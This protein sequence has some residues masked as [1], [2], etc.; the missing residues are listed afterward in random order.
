MNHLEAKALVD[1]LGLT[2]AESLYTR[3]VAWHETNYGGGW[4]P[5]GDKSNNMGA[6]LTTHPDALSFSYQDSKFDDA[7]GKVTQYHAQF[8]GYPTPRDGF[9]ALIATLLKP[10]V[11]AALASGNLEGAVASQYTN[12]YFQGLHSHATAQ[13][14]AE[15]VADYLRAVSSALTNIYAATHEAQALLPKDRAPEARGGSSSSP[16]VAPLL[17]RGEVVKDGD[18]RLR[19]LR[20]GDRGPLIRVWQTLLRDE[21]PEEEA[22]GLTGVFDADTEIATRKWQAKM[23]LPPDGV[24]GV[25]SWSRMLS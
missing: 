19:T 14:N 10:N 1:S 4:K 8:A 15:N 9:K 11:R 17:S 2:P 24:V 18:F 20:V 22:L 3:A 16:P 5:P 7:A 6:I 13:G 12:G 23:G 21:Q 25:L